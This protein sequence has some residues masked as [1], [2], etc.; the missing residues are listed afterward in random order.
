MRLESTGMCACGVCVWCACGVC[1]WYACGMCVWCAC[2]M[3]VWCACG[4]CVWCACGMCVWCVCGMCVWC[5]CGVCVVCVYGVRVVCVWYVCMVCVWYVCMVCMWYVCMVCVWYVCTLCMW[6]V[7]IFFCLVSAVFLGMC[8][9]VSHVHMDMYTHI[10]G[11]RRGERGSHTCTMMYLQQCH[12]PAGL[13]QSTVGDTT[14]WYVLHCTCGT[15]SRQACGT[16]SHA[17]VHSPT[18]GPA[19]WV[20]LQG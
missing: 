12:A 10:A 13:A 9:H 4:V 15:C 8:I 20:H 11:G 18:V 17:H 3:C 2:G 16:L 5:A 7:C 19:E 6:Y 14:L 1:V